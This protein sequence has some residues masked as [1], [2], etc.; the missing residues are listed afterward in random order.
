[1]FGTIFIHKVILEITAWLSI[2]W[3]RFTNIDILEGIFQICTFFK[4][5][6]DV[7]RIFLK[8]QTAFF[9][10]RCW[11]LW[12]NLIIFFTLYL[13]HFTT[14]QQEL[15]ED[16]VFLNH[17]L[18]V[19]LIGCF[20]ELLEWGD[21]GLAPACGVLGNIKAEF[22]GLF[23]LKSCFTSKKQKIMTKQKSNSPTPLYIQF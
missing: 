3:F 21:G 22:D 5:T 6:I 17:F 4:F 2:K 7:F 19:T 20:L 15:N 9:C 11:F 18:R 1:M 10:W 14:L 8:F 13:S 23:I 12:K 16:L